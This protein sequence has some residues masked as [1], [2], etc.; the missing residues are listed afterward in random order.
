MERCCPLC[1]GG[2]VQVPRDTSWHHLRCARPVQGGGLSRRWADA[3]SSFMLAMSAA[4]WCWT[5]CASS[6]LSLP[7]EAMSIG[8]TGQ[9]CCQKPKSFVIASHSLYVLHDPC[10][11]TLEPVDAG[12]A[13]VVFG[14]SHKPLAETL[15]GVF[16]LNP[17]SAGP[18]RFRLPITVARL[19]VSAD[20]LKPEIV[21]LAAVRLLF[22]KPNTKPSV[23]TLDQLD[24]EGCGKYGG[25]HG[26]EATRVLGGHG[27]CCAGCVAPRLG[28]VKPGLG[29]SVSVRRSRTSR[30]ADQRHAA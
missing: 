4:P 9:R 27:N 17:G 19:H 24:R 2:L 21:R 12:M 18:Q 14:H 30:L 23:A 6:R 28:R 8:R 20:R 5:A 3:S 22:D 11:L 10:F 15:D 13:A 29:A 7:C 26:T 25:G 1:G 16:Y